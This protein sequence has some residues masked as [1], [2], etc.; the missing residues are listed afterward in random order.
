MRDRLEMQPAN[1]A[2]G[3]HRVLH[4]HAEAGQRLVRCRR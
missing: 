3:A 1:G 2:L 4:G